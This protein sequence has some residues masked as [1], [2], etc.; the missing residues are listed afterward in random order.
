MVYNVIIGS[1][2][3]YTTSNPFPPLNCY[4]GHMLGVHICDVHR[5]NSNTSLH[6]NQQLTC[7]LWSKSYM[8]ST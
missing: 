8:Y 6:S 1:S 4:Q 3:L 2:T 7:S 5:R